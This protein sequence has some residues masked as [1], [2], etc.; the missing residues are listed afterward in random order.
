MTLQKLIDRLKEV[1]EANP[2]SEEW[3]VELY[4]DAEN[5]GIWVCPKGSRI[6]DNIIVTF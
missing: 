2:T 3:M 6:M 1:R 4:E 5:D